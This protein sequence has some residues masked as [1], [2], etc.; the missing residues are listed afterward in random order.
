LLDAN[1]LFG[2]LTRDVLLTLAEEDVLDPFWSQRIQE[3]WTR[4]LA[5]KYSLIPA[6]VTRIAAKMN[7]A[8]PNAMVPAAPALEARFPRV[9]PG[10][11]HVAASALSARATHLVTLNGKHF[12]DPALEAAGIK[13]VSPDRFVERLIQEDSGT[14]LHLLER[15]RSRMS[16][17]PYDRAAFRALFRTTGLPRSSRLLPKS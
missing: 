2:A 14:V 17:P 1:T 9:H 5:A 11:R 8:F 13:V 15:M 12:R 16:R 3:E 6:Q 10:D 4:N 7:A